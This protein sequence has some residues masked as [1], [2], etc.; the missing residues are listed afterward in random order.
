MTK[1]EAEPQAQEAG[2]QLSNLADLVAYQD[3][4]VVSRILMKKAG[5]S[6]TAFAFDRGQSLSEHTT[7]YDALVCVVDGEVEISISGK[8]YKLNQGQLLVMPANEPHAVR[9]I[10]RFKMLLTM[11]KS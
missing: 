10:T 3:D 2:V 1:E 6:V 5:G 4:S 11:L 7:P 8:P 9:A